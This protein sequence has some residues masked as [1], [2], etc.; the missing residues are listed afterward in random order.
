MVRR[1]PTLCFFHA[2]ALLMSGR[3]LEVVE[4]RLQALATI[5]VDPASMGAMAGRMAACA[6]ILWSCRPMCPRC[7]LCQQALE[8]LPESDRF[9]QRRGLES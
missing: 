8:M 6:P 4:Q 1:R 2:W 9:I 3:S 7:R 5:Q